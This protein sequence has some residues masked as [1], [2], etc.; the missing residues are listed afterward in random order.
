MKLFFL[1][2]DGTIAIP[3]TDPSPLLRQTIRQL[4]AQGEKVFLCTG[5][6]YS[7]TPESVKALGCDGGI[8]SAGGR[9]LADG[10][11]LF[12][13]FMSESIKDA[14]VALLDKLGAYMCWNAIQRAT[15]EEPA[16]RSFWGIRSPAAACTANCGGF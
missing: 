13:S 12:R 5:R 11:E 1:D 16:F 2:I 7:F 4:Q 9:I 10:Q 3:G 8:F 6:T 14:I 15:G